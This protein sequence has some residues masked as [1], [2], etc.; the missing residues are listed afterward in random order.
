VE[1]SNEG[2]AIGTG[3]TSAQALAVLSRAGKAKRRAIWPDAVRDKV[4]GVFIQNRRITGAY[5]FPVEIR[6]RAGHGYFAMGR[7][8][9][10]AGR[11]RDE[12]IGALIMLVD[13]Q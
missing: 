3:V 2:L 11:T 4:K 10:G 6:S 9:V 8:M 7:G 5:N 1:I 12:A 13:P